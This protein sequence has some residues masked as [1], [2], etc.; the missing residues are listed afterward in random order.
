MAIFRTWLVALTLSV[1]SSQALVAQTVTWWQKSL[2]EAIAAAKD[3]KTGMV[4]LYCWRKD[5]GYCSS[6]FGGTLSD[7][8]VQAQIADMVC[9]GA[10]DAGAT[11][12]VLE[13]YSIQKVPTVLF[14]DHEGKVVDVLVGYL[15][16]QEFLTEVKRIKAGEKTIGALRDAFAKAPTDLALG[17]ELLYKQRRS[18]DLMN[19]KATLEAIV[20]ADPQGKSEAAAEAA[21]L[22]VIDET[23]KPGTAPADWD[24]KALRL[25]AG[26]VKQKRVQFLAYDRLASAEWQKDNLKEAVSAAEKAWKVIPPEFVLDW[27][28]IV[29]GKV[30]EAHEELDKVNKT[31]CKRAIEI[32]E[33]ALAEV[34]KRHKQSP[35]KVW[36]ANALYLHAAVLVVANQRKEAFAAMDRAI[37]LNPND[38]NLKAMKA[39]WVDGNK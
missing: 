26:K 1:S 12:A 32:S 30:Y 6:M 19:A 25:F 17:L 21:L 15:P 11:K 31:I 9:M 16:V 24:T 39:R 13:K 10:E 2:D 18:G 33:K 34:E 20:K 4:L 7:A 3:T 37:E 28:Q 38:E 35:D 27:G 29:A 14:L 8:G 5:D 22:A 23:F 36:L